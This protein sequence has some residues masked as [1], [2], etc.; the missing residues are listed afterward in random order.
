[1]VPWFV[2]PGGSWFVEFIAGC[3]PLS[4]R[5]P[6]LISNPSTA[7]SVTPLY[8]G[9]TGQVGQYDVGGAIESGPNIGVIGS[10]NKAVSTWAPG[11]AKA[12]VNAGAIGIAA[13]PTGYGL[14][15]GTG[16]GILSAV[17]AETMTGYAR[18]VQYWSRVLSDAEIL[19]VTT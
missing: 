3:P 17:P 1:M 9:Q 19:Q 12:C 7:S 15:S 5:T 10:V 14:L 18:R 4:V 6:R 11:A 2:S 16:V 13:M 8:F